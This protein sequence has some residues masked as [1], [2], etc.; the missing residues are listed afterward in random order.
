MKLYYNLNLTILC[1]I[2]K[3]IINQ[4]EK[5]F[6]KVKKKFINKLLNK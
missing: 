1:H 2:Y 3:K 5:F 6:Y 4:L